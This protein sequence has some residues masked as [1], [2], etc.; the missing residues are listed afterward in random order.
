MLRRQLLAPVRLVA[1]AGF[2]VWPALANQQIA[3]HITS[4]L[5]PVLTWPLV[6]HRAYAGRFE[7]RARQVFPHLAGSSALCI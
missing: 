2:L 1:H 3:S 6:T 5:V 7:A 4:R